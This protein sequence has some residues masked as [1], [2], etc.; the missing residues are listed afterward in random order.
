MCPKMDAWPTVTMVV[1]RKK[2]ERKP[3]MVGRT[4][5]MLMAENYS[6]GLE[7]EIPTIEV[8]NV[9]TRIERWKEI[10]N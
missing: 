4:K 1:I 10:S 7:V 3:A 9:R 6:N 8:A 2:S 5:V